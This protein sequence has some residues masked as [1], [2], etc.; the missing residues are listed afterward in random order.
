MSAR[1]GNLMLFMLSML[2]AVLVATQYV[3]IRK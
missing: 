2:A 1:P 3:R